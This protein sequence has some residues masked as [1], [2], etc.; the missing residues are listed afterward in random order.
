[1]RER[2]QKITRNITNK[3]KTNNKDRLKLWYINSYLKYK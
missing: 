1:M 2:K 3:Q